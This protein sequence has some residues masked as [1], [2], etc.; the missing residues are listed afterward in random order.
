MFFLG[1]ESDDK[2]DFPK[3]NESSTHRFSYIAKFSHHSLDAFDPYIAWFKKRL[4][5]KRIGFTRYLKKVNKKKNTK[6]SLS[7]EFKIE[8]YNNFKSEIELIEALLKR[9]LKNWHM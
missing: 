3:V 4:G 5:I 8:L 9:K 7:N 6:E 1:L 2:I